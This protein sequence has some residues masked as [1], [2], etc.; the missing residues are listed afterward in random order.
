MRVSLVLLCLT[1]LMAGCGSNEEGQQPLSQQ[2]VR[3]VA[4]KVSANAT[5]TTKIVAGYRSNYRIERTVDGIVTVRNA[6]TNEVSVLPGV[7]EIQFF[8]MN[9]IFDVEGQAGQVYRLY[10]AAF[11]RKPDLVGLGFWIQAAKNGED[12][13]SISGSFISSNEFKLMYGE[14]VSAA[15][16]VDALYKNVLHRAGEPDGFN[17]WINAVTNGAD[18]RTVLNGFAQSDENRK[19]LL[20][21]MQNGFD[22]VPFSKPA[23]S[24]II[25]KLTSYENKNDISANTRFPGIWDPSMEKVRATLDTTEIGFNPRSLSFGDFMQDGAYSAFV[26]SNRYTNA[27]PSNNPARLPDS[28]GIVRFLQ[29]GVDGKWSDVTEQLLPNAADRLTCITASYSIVT[30]F[31][32]D[33]KPDVYVACT[34]IDFQLGGKWTHDQLSDQHVYLSRPDGKYQHRIVAD[35]RI[36]GHQATAYDV[37]GD[38]RLDVVSTDAIAHATP[39][40]FF[41]NGDGT[42]RKDITRFPADMKGKA[43]YGVVGVPAGGKTTLVVSGNTPGASATSYGSEYGTQLLIFESG[44]FTY[45]RD[46]TA[47][48]PSTPDGFKFGVALDHVYRNGYLYSYHVSDDYGIDGIVKTD[49]ATGK[50][51]LIYSRRIGGFGEQLVQIFLRSDGKIVVFGALCNSEDKATSKYVCIYEIDS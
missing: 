40:I 2:Q 48:L 29:K 36:Y 21:D 6:L 49:L 3:Q 11:N 16:F 4:A 19:N 35:S 22:Y 31:N 30:D 15:K 23:G 42:F 17:W 27:Y 47:G 32:N 34:G 8:D 14:D 51:Q 5:E 20:P 44:A 41:G 7:Q 13:T 18:R 50:S 43:I 10:Q 38:G 24:P 28:P 25:P 33:G 9:T 45:Q 26:I 1:V 46:L 39:V 12:I 37:D